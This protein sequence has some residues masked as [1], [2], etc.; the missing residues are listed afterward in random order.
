M[1]L[2]DHEYIRK[3]MLIQQKIHAKVFLCI[4]IKKFGLL[5]M[6]YLG[7]QG[8]WVQIISNHRFCHMTCI[9]LFYF[10]YSYCVCKF[11]IQYCSKLI[12]LNKMSNVDFKDNIIYK[13]TNLTIIDKFLFVLFHLQIVLSW[14]NNLTNMQVLN[15]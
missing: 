12:L 5:N 11:F 7:V 15:I 8:S 13:Y 14:L 4:F 6:V 2:I 9:M 1:S 3:N 10:I